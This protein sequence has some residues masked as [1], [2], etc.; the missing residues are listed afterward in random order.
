[1][2]HL[3]RAF[4]DAGLPREGILEVARALSQGLAN[5]AESVR[6]LVISELPEPG[7]S[8]YSLGVRYV[9]A[10]EQMAP[11]VGQV[12]AYQFRVH[13]RSGIRRELVQE[14]SDGG[15]FGA[16]EE[17]AVAFADLVDYTA[18]GERLDAQDVGR[19]AG[20]L[21]ELAAAAV[22]RPVRLVKMIGDA[23]MFVSPEP[24]PLVRAMVALVR[25]VEK[26]GEDF[27]SVRVGMAYGTAT[28]RG[29]DWFG[30]CVNVASRLT[31]TGKAGRI[32]ANES[33]QQQTEKQ[34]WNKKRRRSLK[35][36]EGRVR[37]FELR[38]LEEAK[39]GS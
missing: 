7:D 34:P 19:I 20:R 35:G 39:K 21:G 5:G 6:H 12:L 33:F 37:V 30:S 1:M 3:V 27:P 32:F 31:G 25:A 10:A 26:E 22:R 28:S 8:E 36:V 29:G 15:S 11:L 18:L 38:P 23:A 9:E 2:A 4:L 24:E 14:A 16:V 17:T 13:L